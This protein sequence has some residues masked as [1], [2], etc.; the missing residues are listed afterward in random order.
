VNGLPKTRSF[1]RPSTCLP[2]V[3]R[4][5]WDLRPCCSRAC[6][7]LVGR[8]SVSLRRC[9]APG[10]ASTLLDRRPECGR[11]AASMLCGSVSPLR[12]ANRRRYSGLR[13]LFPPRMRR[14]AT[15]AP[16]LH[17]TDAGQDKSRKVRRGWTAKERRKISPEEQCAFFC[18]KVRFLKKGATSNHRAH[19]GK[20]PHNPSH[21]RVAPRAFRPFGSALMA[22]HTGAM[23]HPRQLAG[24]L[25]SSASGPAGGPGRKR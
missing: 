4:C 20:G 16:L 23:V 9:R 17:T 14:N 7:R 8:S 5:T 25:R 11:R 6:A 10:A 1:G 15:P 3:D 21:D 19:C 2:P 18:R 12:G 13:A 24:R 22:W